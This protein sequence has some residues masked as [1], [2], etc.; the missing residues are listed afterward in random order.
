ML[1]AFRVPI[2]LMLAFLTSACSASLR[3][4]SFQAPEV[5]LSI[6]KDIFPQRLRLGRFP[7]TN[8][9]LIV[10]S[11]VTENCVTRRRVEVSAF[12]LSIVKSDTD[13]YATIYK[14]YF[15]SNS[16]KI[17]SVISCDRCGFYIE[18]SSGAGRNSNF[19]YVPGNLHQDKE[20]ERAILDIKSGVWLKADL[21]IAIKDGSKVLKSRRIRTL[22]RTN[23]TAS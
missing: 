10:Y 6:R 11:S 3:P 1:K 19:A 9:K 4:A 17:G 12:S 18:W 7:E 5:K 8:G 23:L 2:C 16:K 15:H 22:N 14:M 21:L 13:E 20:T